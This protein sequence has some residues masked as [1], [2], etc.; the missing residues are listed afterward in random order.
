MQNGHFDNL[1]FGGLMCA[2]SVIIKYVVEFT[3]MR[4]CTRTCDSGYVGKH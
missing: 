3:I 1:H 4:L 2:I